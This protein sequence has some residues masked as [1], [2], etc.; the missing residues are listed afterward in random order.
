MHFSVSAAHLAIPAMKV[1]G[2]ILAAASAASAMSTTTKPTVRFTGTSGS[3]VSAPIEPVAM[4]RKRPTLMD[5]ADD[6]GVHI[7]RSCCAGTC[8]VCEVKITRGGR[9]RTVR[10]C[11]ATPRDEDVVDVSSG[12]AELARMMARFEGQDGLDYGR[13]AP[14]APSRPAR[15][16][17]PPAYEDAWREPSPAYESPE[18]VFADEDDFSLGGGAAPWDVI[19]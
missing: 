15:P 3:D 16:P 19:Q 11:T 4:G 2:A 10:A 18:P 8:A 6:A 17:P 12:D 13:V 1:C 7:P 5:I 9:E 14:T